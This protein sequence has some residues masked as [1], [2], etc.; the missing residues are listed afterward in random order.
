MSTTQKRPIGV[1]IISL[2]YW[3]STVF[4]LWGTFSM[5][6]G[7]LPLPK[8]GLFT[9]VE[10]ALSAATLV[11]NII[12]ATLLFLLRKQALV[13]FAGALLLNMADTIWRIASNAEIHA[14]SG[15]GVFGTA[16]GQGLG[17]ATVLFVCMYVWWLIRRGVLK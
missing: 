5:L 15:S 1:W 12:G 13:L 6:F 8:A 17:L 14:V 11:S 7:L 10:A 3:F 16:L 9:G 2:F 4:L